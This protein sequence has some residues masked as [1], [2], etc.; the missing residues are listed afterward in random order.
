MC[1]S[2]MLFC[3]KEPSRKGKVTVQYDMKAAGEDQLNKVLGHSL[4]GLSLCENLKEP[5]CRKVRKNPERIGGNQ[6]HSVVEHWAGSGGAVGDAGREGAAASLL[7]P[8]L[9]FW[10]W[11]RAEARVLSGC[12][13]QSVE[14]KS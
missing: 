14:W 9:Y 3:C 4:F 13:P 1:D 8:K 7:Q 5:S 6:G 10:E 12:G 2:P 11:I